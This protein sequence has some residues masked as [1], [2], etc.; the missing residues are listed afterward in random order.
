MSFN[1]LTISQASAI[2]TEVEQIII[3]GYSDL[4]V[5]ANYFDADNFSASI[6][7]SLVEMNDREVTATEIVDGLNQKFYKKYD[8]AEIRALIESAGPPTSDFSIFGE[9]N[10]DNYESAQSLAI[11]ITDKLKN[12]DVEEEITV[13]EVVVDSSQ[14][15]QRKDGKRIL[16]INAK[17]D[18]AENTKG[19]QEILDLMQKEYDSSVV[20]FDL[21]QE[22]QNLESFQ[23]TIVAFAIALILMYGLLVLQYNSFI[24]PLL[25]FT[26]IPMGFIGVFPGLYY[27]DNALS[28]FTMLG[29]IGLSGIVVNNTIMMTDYINNK[30]EDGMSISE[31]IHA[32]IISRFRPIIATTATTV[33][34]LFPLALSDPFWEP[35]A[36]TMVFGL[37]ASTIMV[38]TVYPVFYSLVETIIFRVKELNLTKFR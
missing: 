1:N 27:T 3:D 12:I 9:I 19:L 16:N 11:E 30:R 29:L 31:A 23:S 5:D 7:I 25:V 17:V 38:L 18:D 10:A 33:G 37:I 2:A 20:S 15:I 6:N 13:V 28:F 24:Q 14:I 26:A 32:A 35:L 4:I 21:G 22:T 36:F 34:G 8:N